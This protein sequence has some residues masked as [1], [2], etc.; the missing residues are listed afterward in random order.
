MFFLEVPNKVSLLN[1]HEVLF[2]NTLTDNNIYS[3]L[4][5]KHFTTI[6]IGEPDELLVV[7][8]SFYNK[9]RE[10][11]SENVLFLALPNQTL[12]ISNVI[13]NGGIISHVDLCFDWPHPL[14]NF[15]DE[16]SKPLR[17]AQKEI[18]WDAF[19]AIP[20]ILLRVF[21]DRLTLPENKEMLPDF[22]KS[23]RNFLG[24]EK[25][26]LSSLKF[27]ESFNNELIQCFNDCIRVFDYA[28]FSE[29]K[30]LCN[31]EWG[32]YSLCKKVAP[33]I[34]PYCNRSFTPVVGTVN[35]DWARPELDHFLP[36]SLFPMFGVSFHNL[37]PSCHCCNHSKGSYNVVQCDTRGELSY[38]ILHPYLR[39]DD[40]T[41]ETLFSASLPTYDIERLFSYD[42]PSNLEIIALPPENSKASNSLKCFR[43]ASMDSGKLHGYYQHHDKEILAS[44][45]LI[46]Q[47]PRRALHEIAMFL[48]TKT[49]LDVEPIVTNVE[50]VLLKQRLIEM[51]MPNDCKNEPLGKLKSDSLEV[52]LRSWID[53]V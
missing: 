41:S 46:H 15:R 32:A 51:V 22:K 13:K 39:I 21:P 27:G 35:E 53:S 47:Y 45:D 28:K 24:S 42:E 36:K 29:K 16:V 23:A 10:Q 26:K 20:E 14:K 43:L 44:L 34:C 40:Q 50:L 38:K 9:I 11:L 8:R 5:S 3:L 18:A 49:V 6:L 37:I 31:T 1:K 30:E 19:D 7:L 52:L 48:N 25:L 4:L 33:R 2:E 12:N 17:G